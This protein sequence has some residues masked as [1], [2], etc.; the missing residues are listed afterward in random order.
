M[1]GGISILAFTKTFGTVFLGAP[2]Q[3]LKHEP[4]EVS[5]LMLLPLYF[6][7]AVMF[8]ISFFPGTLIR[9]TGLIIG[10]LSGASLNY[11][12]PD[13]NAYLTVMRSISL[14]SAV[15]LLISAIVMFFR[16]LLTRNSDV[17]YSSTWGCGY[18]APNVRMQYTGKSFSKSFGKLM[19]FILIEKKGYNEIKSDDVFPEPRRYNSF[20]LDFIEIRIIDPVLRLIS[21]FIN[22][23]QFIQNGKI[24]AYVIYG[25][26]FILVIF[27]GTF[28]NFWN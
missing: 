20:Y 17:Q 11:S 13:L 27:I 4:A 21:R 8:F 18:T 2:R 10:D 15:F 6:I 22:L 14:S 3:T 9:I 12:Q 23:F 26:I 24:Q 16:W 28:L 25:I 19:N 5:S 1:I 7:V